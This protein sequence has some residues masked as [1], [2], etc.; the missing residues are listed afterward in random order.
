MPPT[1]KKVKKCVLAYSGGLDTS[2][3][4]RWLIEQYGCEVVAFSADLGQGENLKPLRA[5]A[6]KTGASKVIIKDL[7]EEFTRDF[8]VP[9]IQANALYEGKYPL[10]TALGRP[11]IAKWLVEIAQAE[12]AD[13]IAHGCTGKGNDQ[14]R[15]EVVTAA[16]GP[17]LTCLA[18]V[19]EWDLKTREQEMEYA[20]KH[21]I[22]VQATAEKPY[23]LDSNMW[24][25]SIECGVLE[26]PSASP[27]ESAWQS[28]RSPEKAPQRAQEVE[29]GFTRGVPDRLNGK[30][31][32]TSA[33]I[34]ELN[35]IGA[36]HGVG[37]VDMVEN[38]LVGIKSRELYEAPAAVQLLFA[39]RELEALC[40][41]REVS[42]FK[43][44]LENKFAELAYYGLWF[45]PLRE[46]I[47]AFMEETQKRVTGTVRLRL[48]KGSVTVTGRE[49]PSSLYDAALATYDEGDQFDQTAAEGFIKIFGLPSK[50]QAARKR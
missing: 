48:F 3:I 31:M 45:S 30:R 41:D 14:V 2:V 24:G 26:D 39:H 40:L 36:R 35:R 29:I 7:R 43:P 34:A 44:I 17:K 9:A 22:P 8:I 49:S 18:P 37:R 21:R 46:A 16:L 25:T 12:K 19:R 11:L 28:T 32:K 27:P 10:A 33:L 50:V 4:I 15:F 23:S 5:K 1:K 38:R 47:S 13:A 42:H 6:L 20:R